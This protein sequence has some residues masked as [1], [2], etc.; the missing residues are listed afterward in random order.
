LQSHVRQAACG[1]YYT[2]YLT[3]PGSLIIC[4]WRSPGAPHQLTLDP[5]ILYLFAGFDVPAAIAKDGSFYLFQSDYRLPPRQFRLTSPVF[6]I[7]KGHEFVIVL[8]V[9]GIVHGNGVFNGGAPD[10]CE[11]DEL[12]SVKVRRIFANYSIAAVLT[13]DGLVFLSTAESR[14]FLKVEALEGSRIVAM[15]IGQSSCLFVEE[16][17]KLFTGGQN[18][19]GELMLG[20]TDEAAVVI[21][22][23][24]FARMKVG[25]VKCGA[26]HSFAIVNHPGLPHAGA[27]HFGV[28]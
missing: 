20:R 21:T 4:G 12:R 22:E 28:P 25:G 5:P 9:D 11:L 17:G 15:D 6:D 16:T 7:A 8:T 10:F 3:E 26:H 1:Q 19:F 13:V 24:P 14:R 18:T 27:V 2:A 23:G